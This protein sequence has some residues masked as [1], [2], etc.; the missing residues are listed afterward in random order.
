MEKLDPQLGAAAPENE[1]PR[2]MA[3]R[4]KGKG[5]ER[6]KKN[7]KMANKREKA[8]ATTLFQPGNSRGVTY[9]MRSL[10]CM[11]LICSFRKDFRANDAI[12]AADIYMRYSKSSILFIQSER[13]EL[14]LIYS[15]NLGTE[16]EMSF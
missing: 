2:L 8:A 10:S 15:N 13:F 4:K 6:E 14:P 9:R 11:S 7:V 5:P 12:L 1:W 16:L 3:A